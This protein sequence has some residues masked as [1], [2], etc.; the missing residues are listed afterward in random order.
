[1]LETDVSGQGLGAVLAQKQE[2]TD[3]TDSFCQQN[4]AFPRVEL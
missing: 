4:L 2:D 1:M 3:S